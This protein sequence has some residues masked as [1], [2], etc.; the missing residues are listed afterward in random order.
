MLSRLPAICQLKT[1]LV[2]TGFWQGPSSPG[3][4][5][6]TGNG[7]VSILL[8]E[9]D[10]DSLERALALSP[11]RL[12]RRTRASAL[13][14]SSLYYPR[15]L[16][17]P[18]VGFW[19]EVLIGSSG[20]L[21]SPP[22]QELAESAPLDRVVLFIGDCIW[23][24]FHSTFLRKPVAAVVLAAWPGKWSRELSQSSGRSRLPR[25]QLRVSRKLS[26]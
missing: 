24:G 1:H 12:S 23:S 16:L 9:P 4:S 22:I 25:F 11:A 20:F 10:S 2:P 13:I 14:Q 26:Q 6:H 3:S 17:R 7:R 19:N 15:A 5:R 18:C 8:E 21:P